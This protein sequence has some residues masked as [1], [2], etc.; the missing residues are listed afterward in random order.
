MKLNKAIKKGFSLIEITL[1]LSLILLLGISGFWI[2]QK[3]YNS[4]SANETIKNIN[5][6]SSNLRSIASGNVLN[7]NNED[8]AFFD[9][10]VA[11]LYK[12]NTGK[13]YYYADNVLF[14]LVNYNGFIE[15]KLLVNKNICTKIAS[16]LLSTS[17]YA[18]KINPITNLSTLYVNPNSSTP[19]LLKKNQ[20][21]S[22][23]YE[24]GVLVSECNSGVKSNILREVD[25]NDD[26]NK[27][28]EI[29]IFF[30]P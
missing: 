15:M 20:Y 28:S 30:Y 24:T 25:I 11:D 14:K 5:L 29:D 12:R 8:F 17:Q 16:D 19:S 1:A 13:Y 7:I 2:Q 6:M 22:N 27:Y 23:N 26:N 18:I 3:V 4:N 9:Y 21:V 10:L